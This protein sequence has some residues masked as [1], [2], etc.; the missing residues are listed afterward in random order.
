MKRRNFIK[1]L[2]A[3]VAVA[4]IKKEK[5][6]KTEEIPKGKELEYLKRNMK[7]HGLLA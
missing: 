7:L 5:E 6:Q 1:G 4:T 3:S 2:A